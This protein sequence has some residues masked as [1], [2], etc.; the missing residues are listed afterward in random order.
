MYLGNTTDN[1]NFI[2]GNNILTVTNSE[3]LRLTVGADDELYYFPTHAQETNRKEN[4]M[5]QRQTFLD[6]L[7]D[8]GKAITSEEREIVR[9]ADDFKWQLFIARLLARVFESADLAVLKEKP[10]QVEILTKEV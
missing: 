9:C 8:E 2:Y 3:P 7:T 4:D 6:A 1:A 10:K 5:I